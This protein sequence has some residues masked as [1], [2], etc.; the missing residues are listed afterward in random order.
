MNKTIKINLSGV[1]F[2]IDEKAYLLLREYLR[3][4]DSRLA[5]FPGGT[6]TIEDIESRIA[7]ILQSMKGLAGIVSKENVEEIIRII[8]KPEEF[9]HA[10][11]EPKSAHY[12]SSGK[13][14]F[15]N[16]DDT[17]IAGVCGGI[18]TYLN[19]DAVW[20][21]ILF[22]L[23]TMFF[24]VGFFVYLALWIALPAAQNDSQKKDMYG[25]KHYS[26]I[27]QNQ[28]TGGPD[29]N[30]NSGIGNAVN[31]IFRAFGRVFHVFFRVIFIIIGT[32]F[33]LAGFLAIFSFV[34]IFIFRYPG[35]LS[36]NSDAANL[37]YIPH[38]LSFFISPAV[39]PVIVVLTIIIIGLPLFAMIYWGIKMIFWFRAKE[40]VYSLIALVIWVLSIA[41]LTII[42]FGEGISFAESAKASSEYTLKEPSDTVYI[43]SGRTIAG[44]NY[45][46]KISF[47]DDDYNIFINERNKEV[48]VRT[49]LKIEDSENNK[50]TVEVQKRSSGKTRSDAL[51]KAEALQYKF[52]QL[53]DT[54]FLDE[55]FSYPEGSKWAFDEVGVVLNIPEKK[56]V[57]LDK[58]AGSLIPPRL[59]GF[60]NMDNENLINDKKFWRLTKEGFIKT[61]P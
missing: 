41:A 22:I 23:F 34:M 1:L 31:E 32:S 45:D 61:K 39:T 21:R 16:P 26:T 38:F 47:P 35:A 29:L 13:R 20:I 15:R 25:D 43:R 30:R 10:E 60:Y 7:E 53:G 28:Q 37:S 51:L 40:G 9:D 17:I 8:G 52:N 5:G 54:L 12:T 48:F 58:K 33:V 46:H 2:Q 42:L 36:N 49:Y 4:I 56:V 59:R 50:V 57:L 44:L 6:E 14:M 27:R 24:G 11:N 19:T 55:Y 18:G 3:A